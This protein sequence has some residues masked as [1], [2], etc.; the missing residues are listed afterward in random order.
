[1]IPLRALYGGASVVE[2]DPHISMGSQVDRDRITHLSVVATQLYD[3]LENDHLLSSLMGMLVGGGTIPS[4]LIERSHQ[5]SLP[6]HTTYG[7]T[8]LGSQLTTTP[9]KSSLTTLRSAGI[10][11]G[12]WHIQH[13]CR[14]R[15]P[16]T[17]ISFVSWVLEWIIH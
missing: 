6:I 3:L 14:P 1:M 13:W 7:M 11:I 12:D 9:P 10:P 5:R 15:N 16:G 17:G 8:E 2:K 4:R